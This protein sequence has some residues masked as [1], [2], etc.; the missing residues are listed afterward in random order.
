MQI[1][2]K[3]TFMGILLP[4]IP[5]IIVLSLITIQRQGLG[6]KI[7]AVIDAQTRNELSIIA[8]NVHSFCETQNDTVLRTL[9][10]DM[11]IAQ[12]ILDGSGSISLSSQS[13]TWETKNQVTG[14]LR[15][16]TLPRLLIG[17]T[18]PG[19]VTDPKAH[20]PVVDDVVGLGACRT[21]ASRARRGGIPEIRV[22]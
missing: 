10:N 17:K 4:L 3:I 7:N 22:A 18:W 20:V 21:L 6:R 8:T 11:K 5:V 16:I 12:S 14:D 9:G 13:V 19:I 2:T 1:R 15:Q